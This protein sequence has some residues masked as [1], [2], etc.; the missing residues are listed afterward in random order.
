MVLALILAGGVGVILSSWNCSKVS[1]EVMTKPGTL[2]V[3]CVF[4]CLFLNKLQMRE[5]TL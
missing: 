5:G 4:A 2:K 1:E 3:L